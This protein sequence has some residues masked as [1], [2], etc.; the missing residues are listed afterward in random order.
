MNW[1]SK[2]E[3]VFKDADEEIYRT[4][5]GKD[6][7][8]QLGQAKPRLLCTLIHKFGKKDVEDFNQFIKELESQPSKSSW[9]IVCICR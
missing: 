4:R 9:G 1:T 3:G 7:M 8:H 6:L 5:S 2:F